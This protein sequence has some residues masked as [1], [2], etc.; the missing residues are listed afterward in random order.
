MNDTLAT[1]LVQK[2]SSESKLSAK[3][4][5]HEEQI[6]K[7]FGGITNVVELCLT[8]SNATNYI[9]TNSCEFKALKQIIDS[10]E[11]NYN[12]N[13]HG[14][15]KIHSTSQSMS[16]YDFNVNSTNGINNNINHNDK[17]N[18]RLPT[19]TTATQYKHSK[20]IIDCYPTHNLLFRLINNGNIALSVYDIILSKKTLIILLC[21][22]C[23]SRHN[24][25]SA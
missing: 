23:I 1:F 20:L 19:I 2:E 12:D 18:Q 22:I 17:S 3:L 14:D 21:S 6:I 10:N 7:S 16:S 8:H 13:S 24:D 11:D 15:E 25:I 5:E 4:S 9:D